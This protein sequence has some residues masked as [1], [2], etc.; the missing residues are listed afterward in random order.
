MKFLKINVSYVKKK[1]KHLDVI[2]KEIL[3]VTLKIN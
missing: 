3:A 1:G 2:M